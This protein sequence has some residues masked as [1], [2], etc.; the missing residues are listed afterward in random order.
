MTQKHQNEVTNSFALSLLAAEITRR[1]YRA[2]LAG[3]VRRLRLRVSHPA[4]PVR[5]TVIA[6]DSGWFWWPEARRMA[7][8]S[9]VIGAARRIIHLLHVSCDCYL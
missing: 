3:P 1:G 8:M 6:A 2:V 9:D 4:I 5:A 7:V